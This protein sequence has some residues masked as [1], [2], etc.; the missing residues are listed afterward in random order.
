MKNHCIPFFG[1]EIVNIILVESHHTTERY[2]DSIKLPSQ[3]WACHGQNLAWA[4]N[5][6]HITRDIDVID[7]GWQLGRDLLYG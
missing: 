4:I 7:Q 1:G 6:N 5:G 3:S 2:S